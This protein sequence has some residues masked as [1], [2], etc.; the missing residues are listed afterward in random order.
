MS[1]IL[2]LDGDSKK[3]LKML[4]DIISSTNTDPYYHVS[5]IVQNEMDAGATD[6]NISFMR[7]G[8]SKSG[9]V[10]K[11]TIEGNGFGFL[12]SF[13]HYRKNIGDSTKKYIEEY[14]RRSEQGLSRGQFCIGLQGFRAICKEI[15]L[16]NKTKK[17]IEPKRVKNEDI[18][19]PEFS[20][21]FNNRKMI[22]R[23]NTTNVEIQ[24][25]DEFQDK[26][27]THGVTCSLLYPKMDLKSKN[28]VSFLSTNKRTDLLANKD[29]QIKIIDGKYS[30]IV[31][32]IDYKGK[33]EVFEKEHPKANT[34]SNF[35]GLGKVLAT[36]YFHEEK[37]GSKVRLDVK[38]EPIIMDI[39]QQEEFNVPPSIP[40]VFHM[41]AE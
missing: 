11:I 6:I 3:L 37:T 32:P 16:V 36:L 12:E 15:H 40:N 8:G 39:T 34:N 23:T 19:D 25:E 26:R 9:K 22:L 10:K 20:K 17:G 35:R 4:L 30:K 13:E 33:K 2:A 5:E 21:M 38:K 14:C 7:G 28:L 29:L 1:E 41:L 27:D 24:G 31:K 18:D